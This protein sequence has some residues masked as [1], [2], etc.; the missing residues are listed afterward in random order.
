MKWLI[1]VFLIPTLLFSQIPSGEDDEYDF[2]YMLEEME[3]DKNFVDTYDLK[4]MINYFIEDCRKHSISIPNKMTI[5]ATLTGMANGTMA[6]ALGRDDDSIIHIEID[7][8]QWHK[9]QIEKR[10]YILY[11]ELGHDFLNL[12]HGEGGK[13]MYNIIERNYTWYD[14]VRDKETMFKIVK[15]GLYSYE[16]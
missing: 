12:R 7:P 9:S 15:R 10:W 4:G 16:H 14:F 1:I 11:H 8:D 5:D 6:H 13:M 2:S 3:N